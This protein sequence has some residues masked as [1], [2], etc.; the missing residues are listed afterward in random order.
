MEVLCDAPRYD[1]VSEAD[2]AIAAEKLD[3]VKGDG[4][5]LGHTELFEGLSGI[6]NWKPKYK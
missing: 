6:Q 5:N 1:I 3:E 2:L 4:H